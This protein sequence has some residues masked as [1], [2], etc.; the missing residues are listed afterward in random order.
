MCHGFCKRTSYTYSVSLIILWTLKFVSVIL[1]KII[2]KFKNFV[3]ILWRITDTNIYKFSNIIYDFGLG[4]MVWTIYWKLSENWGGMGIA[5]VCN[6]DKFR[7]LSIQIHS[8]GYNKFHTTVLLYVSLL[9]S[10]F[11]WHQSI[12]RIYSLSER[13]IHMLQSVLRVF[14]GVYTPNSSP[15]IHEVKSSNLDKKHLAHEQHT[16]IALVWFKPATVRSWCV[17]FSHPASQ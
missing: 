14:D 5:G 11:Q 16:G 15:L 7:H 13:I 2:T 17:L 1:H 6:I 10:T 4:W 8:A 12:L 3:I 9:N